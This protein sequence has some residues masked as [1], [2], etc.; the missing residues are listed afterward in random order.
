LLNFFENLKFRQKLFLSYAFVI[1]IAVFVLSFY[2][3]Q[4]SSSI[5]R[6]RAKHEM[7]GMADQIKENIEY[8]IHQIN[9]NNGSLMLDRKLQEI[10]SLRGTQDIATQYENKTYVYNTIMKIVNVNDIFLHIT[11]YTEDF[12]PENGNL[13]LSLNRARHLDWF[14]NGINNKQLQWL[15]SDGELFATQKY[16]GLLDGNA[17]GLI[18][19]RLNY[20]S[21]FSF[22]NALPGY[23]IEILDKDNRL[24]YKNTDNDS[25][26]EP[27]LASGYEVMDNGS[28]SVDR[29]EYLIMSRQL[30]NTGWKLYYYVPV[31]LMNYQPQSF[32]ITTFTVASICIIT[33]F[34]IVGLFTKTFVNRIKSLHQKMIEVEEGNLNVEMSSGYKDEIGQL[35]N[36]CGNM[37]RNVNELQQINYQ[38]MLTQKDAEFKALQA[39]INPHF[40]HNILSTISWKAIQIDA[41]DI[42]FMTKRLSDFYRTAINQGENVISVRDEIENTISY[43]ELQLLIHSNSFEVEYSIDERIYN[44]EMLN[45]ILQPIIEN[46]IGHGIE[47]ILK[48]KGLLRFSAELY[49]GKLRF[50]IYDNGP[51]MNAETFWNALRQETNRYGMRNVQDRIK[52]YYGN[53]YGLSL[54]GETN[55]GATVMVTLP[56][57]AR[58]PIKS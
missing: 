46:A 21:M 5:L 54:S 45:L 17:Y 4:Q 51:G 20:N 53:D 7:S 32:F 52:L 41:E 2:S 23:C 29:N 50:N 31:R 8:K 22:S 13:L 48:G 55:E 19:Y 18:Y 3:Y 12:V 9:S 11:I 47:K 49:N 28:L 30:G 36:Q 38:S 58:A 10:C 33:L 44:Y 40:L 14:I 57:N 27:F 26:I 56:L 6:D 25:I 43:I 35:T 42:Y 34:L 1:L 15:Y 39:Q 37:L 16:Y 24:I